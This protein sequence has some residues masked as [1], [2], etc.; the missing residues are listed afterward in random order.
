MTIELEFSVISTSRN[1]IAL[2]EQYL[3]DFERQTH[4]HVHLRVLQW[5]T[6]RA[7]LVKYG[8]Y[9]QGVDVS[10]AGS[11][12]VSDFIGMNVLRPFAAVEVEQLGGAES[13]VSAAWKSGHLSGEEQE[14]WAIPWMV[15]PV[16]I[17][18]RADWLK[19]AGVDPSQGFVSFDAFEQTLEQLQA[20]GCPLPLSL[21][22]HNSRYGT[23]H[24]VA[25]WIWW[26]GSDFLSKD[27]KQVLFD[28]PDA[29]AGIAR[30]Y[31]L[32]RY[33]GEALARLWVAEQ[34]QL[35]AGMEFW[36]GNAA[37]TVGG[38]WLL[39]DTL[40]VPEVKQNAAVAPLPAPA[41][42]GAQSLVVW[43]HSHN[44]AAALDL[45]R[46]LTQ[47]TILAGYAEEL[48]LLPARRAILDNGRSVES[49]TLAQVALGG[50]SFPA[51]RLLG[52]V[53]D[54][55]SLALENLW[56]E[57][58]KPDVDDEKVRELIEKRLGAVARQL[59]LTLSS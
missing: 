23:L 6:A 9:R 49:A 13:F 8:L 52:L 40:M 51:A 19:R 42:V 50:R 39:S 29:L 58:L 7:E 45:V 57:I 25:S 47:P 56:D 41:F 24:N 4:V 2:L 36:K 5:A 38:S 21:P 27:G 34:K 44:P 43:R 11:T 32:R 12:W 31:A 22:V 18:Y 46:Y 33:F 3:A 20:M 28:H 10:E 14:V 15:S 17:V 16:L 37:I 30:Y 35:R 53:E 1:Q 54:K 55:L 59:N 48:G 26:A